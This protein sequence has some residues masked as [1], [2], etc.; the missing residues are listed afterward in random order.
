M[1]KNHFSFFSQTESVPFQD[2]I[3][4]LSDLKQDYSCYGC[5][6]TLELIL[7]VHENNHPH[8]LLFQ[9]SATTFELPRGI[10]KPGEDESLGVVR[11]LNQ[12]LGSPSENQWEMMETLCVYYRPHFELFVYPYLPSHITKPKELK[13]FILIQM[14]STQVLSVPKNRKLIAV[15]LYDLYENSSK[16]GPILPQLCLLISKFHFIYQ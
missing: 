8:L 15:P 2:E 7:I 16:F 4:E 11:I 3:Q 1:E 14:P 12:S 9:T 5:R 13:K 6:N 10:L